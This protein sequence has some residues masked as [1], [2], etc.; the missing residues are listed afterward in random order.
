M[1][2][3]IDGHLVDMT[4]VK[5]LGSLQDGLRFCFAGPVIHIVYHDNTENAWP[6]TEP[7]EAIKNMQPWHFNDELEQHR[8]VGFT[9]A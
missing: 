8:P 6:C 1:L 4:A 3:D 2:F 5:H 9:D 7:K